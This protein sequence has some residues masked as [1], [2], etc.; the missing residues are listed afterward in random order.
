MVEYKVTHTF[1][2]NMSC[3]S[4]IL[5]P[6]TVYSW[7]AISGTITRPVLPSGPQIALVLDHIL[8]HIGHNLV[9][10]KPSLEF[11]L[12]PLPLE[13]LPLPQ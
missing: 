6:N 8:P 12:T 4:P 5:V 2:L 9:R 1:H 3:R 11:P 7:S 13:R 10:F